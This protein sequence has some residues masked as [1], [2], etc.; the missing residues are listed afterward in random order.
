MEEPTKYVHYVRIVEFQS[1]NNIEGEEQHPFLI[2]IS[3]PYNTD[4]EA[5]IIPDFYEKCMYAALGTCDEVVVRV[6]DEEGNV[7][8]WLEQKICIPHKEEET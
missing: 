5:T 8:H 1:W 7:W 3:N 6:I 2:N 4:D